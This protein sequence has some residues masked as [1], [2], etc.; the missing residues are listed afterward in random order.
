MQLGILEAGRTPAEIEGTFGSFPD[1]FDR[2]LT[3]A[4]PTLSLTRWPVVDGVFPPSVSDCDG[5][6]ITG[7]RHG[8]YDPLPWIPPLERFI[9]EA[10]A[11]RRPVAGICFGHQ[12]MAQAL[13]GEVVKAPQGWGLGVQQYRLAQDVP[14][15]AHTPS[16]ISLQVMHQDQVTRVPSGA[17]VVGGNDHCPN[18]ILC[19][20]RYGFSLQPH[21]EFEAPYVEALI[22]SRRGHVFPEPV[23]AAAEP[24][25][26]LPTDR[27]VVAQMLLAF[28]RSASAA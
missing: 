15:M 3:E 13:G 5:W 18:G 10:M 26:G 20:G 22:A 24:S 7:S 19:Y 11:Q 2:L 27:A 8:A 6:L 1:L 14:W 4:D 9:R 17:V 21:P 12:I 28:F 23:V 25:V 16:T